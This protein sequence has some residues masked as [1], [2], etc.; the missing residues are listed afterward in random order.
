MIFQL[1]IRNIN[2]KL[3]LLFFLIICS[4][5]FVFSCSK[6]SNKKDVIE[7]CNILE[8]EFREFET[9]PISIHYGF[10]PTDNFWENKQIKWI[11]GEK[12]MLNKED[13]LYI[14]NQISLLK[15]EKSN[16]SM[17][18][19]FSNTVDVFSFSKKE[20]LFSKNWWAIFKKEHKQNSF[21]VY[22]YPLFNKAHTYA[23]LTFQMY[24]SNLENRTST[25]HI[26][27][28]KEDNNK[29]SLLSKENIV[30]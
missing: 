8:Q 22:T 6:N 26:I 29:W 10:F 17:V 3:F 24:S 4:S 12:S 7:I 16:W 11:E 19:A 1:I 9:I 28:K 20:E 23:F 5:L 13:V 2:M 30:Y 21:R 14:E 25:E 15:S 18:N 27:F